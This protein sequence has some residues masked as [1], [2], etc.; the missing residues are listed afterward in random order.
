MFIHPVTLVH[1]AVVPGEVVA[2]LHSINSIS[3]A[4]RNKK[5][6]GVDTCFCVLLAQHSAVWILQENKS[7][8]T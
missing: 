4:Q 1:V 7:I 8:A 6:C 5:L 2:F 3:N